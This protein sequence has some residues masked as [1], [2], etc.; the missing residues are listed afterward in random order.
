[1]PT[2]ADP[3]PLLHSRLHEIAATLPDGALGVS[4]FDYLSGCAW[5]Y[6]GGRWF[7]AA[8]TIKIAILAAV[9]EA[10]DAERFTPDSRVHVRNYF[11]GTTDGLPFRVQAS[12]DADTGVYA[13]LGRTM[14]ISD[15]ARHM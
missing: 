8:S 1:M 15:L 12:R 4:V 7:H 9:F 6:D 3:G 14:R 10:I 2:A 13:A 11:I 5:H